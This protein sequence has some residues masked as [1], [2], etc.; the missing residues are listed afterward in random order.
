MFHCSNIKFRTNEFA[1]SI[2][3]VV[4]ALMKKMIDVEF[5]VS[6]GVQALEKI[7]KSL[8]PTE[9]YAGE[10]LNEQPIESVLLFPGALTS[11]QEPEN[12]NLT[13][14]VHCDGCHK[15]I[16]GLVYSCETCFDFDLCSDCFPNMSK[17]HAD[18]KHNFKKDRPMS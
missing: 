12:G 14:N 15:E 7:N 16:K 2:D 17:T 4:H 13:I 18:G 9:E 8:I 11:L 6:A 10:W 5:H 1:S 3:D